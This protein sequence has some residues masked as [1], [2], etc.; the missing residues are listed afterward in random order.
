MKHDRDDKPGPARDASPSVALA[1]TDQAPA[2]PGG[3]L[4]PALARTEATP[5]S[6]RSAPPGGAQDDSARFGAVLRDLARAPAVQP[7]DDASG[8][9]IASRYR[10][11]RQVGRGGMGAVYEATQIDLGR[12]VA[13]KMITT[14]DGRKDR[15]LQARFEREARL[16]ASIGHENVVGI[17]EIGHSE[18]DE[19]FIAMELLDGTSLRELLERQE[20]PLPRFLA[21]V[22]QV[23]AGL[24]AAHERRIVHRDIKPENVFVVTAGGSERIKVLDFGISKVLREDPET[25][26]LT[27][28]G[29]MLGTPLYM[30]PEQA[31][32]RKDID[33]RTDLYSVGVLLYRA[34]SGRFPYQVTG[35]SALVFAIATR[36]PPPLR[37]V[38]P[39]VSRELAAIVD[40]LLERDREARFA[41]AEELRRVLRALPPGALEGATQRPMTITQEM[42]AREES[43]SGPQ[44]WV[45]GSSASQTARRLRWPALLGVTV[46]IASGLGVGWLWMA[47]SSNRVPAAPPASAR[48]ATAVPDAVREAPAAPAPA[49][50]ATPGTAAP[51]TAPDT[52]ATA[53]AA[54]DA[55]PA[56]PT[57][58]AV[59]EQIRVHIQVQPPTA[60]LI[61]DGQPVPNPYEGRL[62][63]AEDRTLDVTASAPGHVTRTIRERRDRDI[64]LEFLLDKDTERAARPA[65][66]RARPGS[67]RSRIKKNVE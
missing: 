19:P 33:A 55:T 53:A 24:Q 1:R 44:P 65:G 34:L 58:A 46:L 18:S 26:Q 48:A 17:I 39:A 28:T 23:L 11:E 29:D 12:K 52:P 16:A 5:P 6:Q 37:E 41:S 31:A 43:L 2:H 32:G 8:R 9:T 56:A 35:L 7:E 25:M 59:P 57:A 10:L 14:G 22:D 15:D 3:E 50:P 47:S 45:P 4:D 51:R 66:A 49:A 63:R 27:R 20:L 42:A 61:L 30:S 67:L 60:S 64:R 36:R 21:I 13:I 38:A 40:R 62:A 54:S